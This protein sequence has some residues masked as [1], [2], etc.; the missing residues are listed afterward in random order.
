MISAAQAKACTAWRPIKM[1][2]ERLYCGTCG[3]E[4]GHR[5]DQIRDFADIYCNVCNTL[6]YLM[7]RGEIR[8][9]R[10]GLVKDKPIADAIIP[11]RK[12]LTDSMKCTVCPSPLKGFRDQLSLKEYN[13]S[14]MCQACQDKVFT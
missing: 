7:I 6:N 9:N 11:G 5:F 14:G 13:I 8:P 2:E 3:K 10:P 1:A 4:S 12:A